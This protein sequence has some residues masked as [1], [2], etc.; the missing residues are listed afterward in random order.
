MMKSWNLEL[1]CNYLISSSDL[2]IQSGSITRR[3]RHDFYCKKWLNRNW[4]L[5]IIYPKKL[6]PKF[7]NRTPYFMLFSGVFIALIR[8]SSV[9]FC[10][11][12]YHNWRK[13]FVN[14][15]FSKVAAVIEFSTFWNQ[16][17]DM[18]RMTWRKITSPFIMHLLLIFSLAP[19][20]PLFLD[21][22]TFSWYILNQI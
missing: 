18:N 10:Y 2:R 14:V 9:F 4:I 1:V 3:Q 5:Q 17:L 22:Q 11:W 20:F 21:P 7:S 12:I 8:K 16:L 6:M 13:S 15:C 19:K